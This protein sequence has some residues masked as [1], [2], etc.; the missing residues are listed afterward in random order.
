MG[1]E[2]SWESLLET[3]AIQHGLSPELNPPCILAV[4]TAHATQFKAYVGVRPACSTVSTLFCWRY[5][6]VERPGGLSGFSAGS[7]KAGGRPQSY[8][9]KDIHKLFSYRLLTSL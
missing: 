5:A 4:L 9:I 2:V 8:G 1:A 7:F 6:R 3:V